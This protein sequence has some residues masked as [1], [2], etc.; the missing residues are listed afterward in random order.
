MIIHV[1]KYTLHTYQSLIVK[2]EKRWGKA[3]NKE[4]HIEKGLNVD[5]VTLVYIIN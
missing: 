1:C 4:M 2:L 5:L 3:N